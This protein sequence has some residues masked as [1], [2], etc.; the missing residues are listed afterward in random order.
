MGYE[1][2]S[3]AISNVKVSCIPENHNYAG[4]S[5]SGVLELTARSLMIIIMVIISDLK[6]MI[7]VEEGPDWIWV[8]RCSV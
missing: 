7:K 2:D 6:G 1:S 8:M 3:I 5:L 4:C